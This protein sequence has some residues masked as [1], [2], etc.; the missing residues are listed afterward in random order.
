MTMLATDKP[1]YPIA[2]VIGE[3][4]NDD[5]QL[6]LSWIRPLST[7]AREVGDERTTKELITFV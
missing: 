2:N 4:K 6:R 3:L 7:I 5:I 1:L